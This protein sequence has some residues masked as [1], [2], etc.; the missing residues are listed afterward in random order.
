MIHVLAI[1]TVLVGLAFG[2]GCATRNTRTSF[3]GSLA[4]SYQEFDQTPGSGWRVLAEDEKRYSEAAR[5]IEKYLNQHSE[6][7]RFQ[8]V[9]LH[10]HAAQLLA[11]AGD[12]TA[13]LEH[14][15]FAR[16][17]P[18]PPNSLVR[19]NDYVEATAAFLEGDRARLLAAR[20]RI[21]TNSPGDANLQVVDS[22]VAHFGAPYGIAYRGSR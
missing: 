9:T 10:W 17:A 6:L 19:W 11:I 7:N 20:G 13:A 16:L 18:E 15:P 12:V 1:A 4:L 14:L 8:R 21:A 3:E 22:L 2:A 5:L